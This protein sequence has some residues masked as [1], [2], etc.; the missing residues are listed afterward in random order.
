MA[1]TA[2]SRIEEHHL[3]RQKSTRDTK[4]QEDTPEGCLSGP[5]CPL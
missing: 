5:L 3:Q 2:Q 1:A 4:G